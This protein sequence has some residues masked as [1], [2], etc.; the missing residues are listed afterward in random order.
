[1]FTIGNFSGLIFW[2]KNNL[3]FSD[4]ALELNTENRIFLVS[5]AKIDTIADYDIFDDGTDMSYLMSSF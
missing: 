5:K 4:E 1:M 2:R 3:R